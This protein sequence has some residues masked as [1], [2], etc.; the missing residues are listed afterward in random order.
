MSKTDKE[1]LD[2]ITAREGLEKRG[3]RRVK[4]AQCRGDGSLPRNSASGPY[5]CYACGGKGYKWEGPLR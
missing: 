4:C 3:Y 2:E 5:P 1:L